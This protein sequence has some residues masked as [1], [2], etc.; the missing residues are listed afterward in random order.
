MAA[1][2]ARESA[3]D[4]EVLSAA[5]TKPSLGKDVPCCLAIVRRSKHV[6]KQDLSK[7]FQLALDIS[8]GRPLQA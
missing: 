4:V 5:N 1:A 8:L 7:L 2:N 3:L 6:H